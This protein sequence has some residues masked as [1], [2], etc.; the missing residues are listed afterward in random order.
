VIVIASTSVSIG[1][2]VAQANHMLN[3]CGDEQVTHMLAKL[4]PRDHDGDGVFILKPHLSEGQLFAFPYQCEASTM[5]IRGNVDLAMK[6]WQSVK[7][8]VST[9]GNTRHV[10]LVQP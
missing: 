10:D 7:Y 1:A 8:A 5:P 3:R 2:I 4:I 6:K 9:R